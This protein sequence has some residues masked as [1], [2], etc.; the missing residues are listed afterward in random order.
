MA[1]PSASGVRACPSWVVTTLKRAS[2]KRRLFFNLFI[3]PGIWMFKQLAFHSKQACSCLLLLFLLAYLAGG[4]KAAQPSY[5]ASDRG[6][7]QQLDSF[8]NSFQA[9]ANLN[10]NQSNSQ[11]TQL[12]QQNKNT[13][14]Q[15]SQNSLP[16]VNGNLTAQ[17]YSQENSG[18]IEQSFV[19]NRFY[20]SGNDSVLTARLN[21]FVTNIQYL[22]DILRDGAR[23]SLQCHSAFYQKRSILKNILLD[24][25]NFSASLRYNPLQREFVIYSENRPPLINSNLTEL[26]QQTWGNLELPLVKY[27]ELEKDETYVAVLTLSLRHEEMPPW[28]GKN[29]LFWS[30]V[31]IAP[32][33]YKLE[34]DY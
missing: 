25:H 3:V 24:E 10:A 15:P 13:Q 18:D 33:E 32:K 34:F 5:A 8:T 14:Y 31:V 9:Q 23:L 7:M 16:S 26:L 28:L 1:L 17:D 12:S 22:R 4:A 11:S 30:D 27:S 21:L 6:Q 20:L 19:V 29:V 2:V